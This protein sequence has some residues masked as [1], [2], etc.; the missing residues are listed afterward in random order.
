MPKSNA[1]PI[2]SA[3]ESEASMPEAKSS[4]TLTTTVTLDP[5]KPLDQTVSVSDELLF[6]NNG[7]EVLLDLR[8]VDSRRNP[9][10]TPGVLELR[11][12][13][14]S[15]LVS[16]TIR[17]SGSRRVGIDIKGSIC[18]KNHLEP[19]SVFF[20]GRPLKFVSSSNPPL[21]GPSLVIQP[22]GDPPGGPGSGPTHDG[23]GCDGHG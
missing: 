7:D 2:Q 5:G 20:E 14:S 1:V 18:D 15:R 19:Y 3:L 17:V 4:H 23:P 11:F 21:S 9:V 22:V 10:I 16:T 13:A 12:S 6:I 8:F